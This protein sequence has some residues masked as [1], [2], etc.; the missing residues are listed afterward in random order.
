[1]ANYYVKTKFPVLLIQEYMVVADSEE[2]AIQKALE[3]KIEAETFIGHEWTSRSVEKII[4]VEK[5][6]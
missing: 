6:I 3:G 1:M 5:E 4:A 2:E